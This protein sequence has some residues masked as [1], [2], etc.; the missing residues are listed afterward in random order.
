MI[1]PEVIAEY[2]KNPYFCPK[3]KSDEIRKTGDYYQDNNYSITYTCRDCDSEWEEVYKLVTIQ[4]LDE[5]V[6]ET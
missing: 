5:E 4:S 6:D 3:C 1:E 2:I